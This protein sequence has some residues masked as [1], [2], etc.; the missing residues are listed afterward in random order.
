MSV[1]ISEN[2]CIVFRDE[3]ELAGLIH[4]Q[5][6]NLTLDDTFKNNYMFPV[7]VY[8]G[9]IDAL[10]A[11]EKIPEEYSG[12]VQVGCVVHALS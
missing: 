6:L 9:M 7:Q 10:L 5:L 4:S 11:E 1:C 2:L 12:Q 8:F 3:F